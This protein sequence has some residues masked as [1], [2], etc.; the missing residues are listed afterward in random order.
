MKPN[1]NAR[2]ACG[3]RVT[4]RDAVPGTPLTVMLDRKADTCTMAI[5]VGG[6]PLF[7]H[8]LAMRAPTR[9]ADPAQPDYEDG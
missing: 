1:L 3:C 2:L 5:H 9:L 8:R 4:V 7:D 6:M